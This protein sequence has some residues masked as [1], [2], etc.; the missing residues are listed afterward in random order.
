MP[1][2]F[3]RHKISCTFLLI[4]SVLILYMVINALIYYVP[5]WKNMRPLEAMLAEKYSQDE[6]RFEHVEMS[7]EKQIYL[8]HVVVSNHIQNSDDFLINC[9]E[10]V[11]MISDYAK[12]HPGQFALNS[13]HSFYLTFDWEEYYTNQFSALEFSNKYSYYID[14]KREDV[15]VYC[16]NLVDVT[17][18]SSNGVRGISAFDKI[19]SIDMD[20]GSYEYQEMVEEAVK[21]PNLK[22]IEMGSGD[23]LPLEEKKKYAVKLHEKG[24]NSSLWESL[25]G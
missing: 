8:I 3:R 22:F 4:V 2:F 7:D 16:D 11:K 10:I 24:I 13:K 19:M 21:M 18:R 5:I 17:I 25:Y 20:G 6:F 23:E 1:A 14:W 12:Q 15:T 9:H